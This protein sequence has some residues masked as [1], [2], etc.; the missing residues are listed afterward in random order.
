MQT[1]K[2]VHEDNTNL[3]EFDIDMIDMKKC[4]LAILAV[5]TKSKENK[6]DETAYKDEE[7]REANIKTH[8]NN[9]GT[10]RYINFC[11]ILYYVL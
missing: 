3:K 1:E 5:D 10:T 11:P 2:A 9:N 6:K 8:L 7:I 4:T